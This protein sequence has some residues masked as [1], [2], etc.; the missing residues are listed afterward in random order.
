MEAPRKIKKIPVRT[1]DNTAEIS[2]C[3]MIIEQLGL[4]L[5]K[6]YLFN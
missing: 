3:P 5:L 2:L 6:V 4:T 1:S